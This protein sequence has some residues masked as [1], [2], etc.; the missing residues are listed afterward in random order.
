MAE[1]LPHDRLQPSLLDRLTDDEPDKRTEPPERR[2]LTLSRLRE[3]TLRDLNWLF[4]ATH[5]AAVQDL[6]AYPEVATSTLNY[7]LPDLS[8][9]TASSVHP[10][11]L[12]KQIQRAVWQF[13]PRLGRES[14]RVRVARD[15]QGY[16]HN[17]IV[18]FIEADLWAQP[19]PVR[20]VLRTDLDL[21]TGEVR[22]TE[23]GSAEG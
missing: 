9:R 23:A 13:E 14:V 16:S 2:V 18:I 1:L 12:E 20:L 17:A 8:G 7:G 5:L 6:D 22:V 3:C 4:N 19:A 21:E 10:P 15:Q 11:T